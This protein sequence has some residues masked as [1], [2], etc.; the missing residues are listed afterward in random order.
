MSK[1]C[2][3]SDFHANSCTISP[4]FDSP[5]R[6]GWLQAEESPVEP[7]PAAE[8]SLAAHTSPLLR[9]CTLLA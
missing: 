4:E 5:I 2:T 9:L 8:A 6:F 1:P 7:D 3:T